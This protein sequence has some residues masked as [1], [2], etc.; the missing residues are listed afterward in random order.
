[1]EQQITREDAL[2]RKG[3]K[4][5]CHIMLYGDSSA[6][7]FG[8]IPIKHI[9]LITVI[10]MQ[11]R[12]DGLLGFPG[13]LVNPSNETLEA[14]LSRE[15]HEE[16]GVAVPVGV[17]NHVSTC[18]SSSCPGLI[19]HFYIKKMA[20]SEL[21]ELETAAVAKATDHGLEV[22]GMV[23]VP[24]YFLRNGGGLPYFLSHS[25]ISNSR[26]QLLSALQ[27]CRLLSQ[28]EIEKAVSQA[29]QMRRTRS[30]DPH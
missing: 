3:Y 24:L 1:M 6:K 9:V 25:F 2:T 21:K 4:H 30:G 19:T 16:V 23:R 18:L 28:G 27:R 7:L 13:G 14:G 15:L 12:F 22:L 5:A 11:M 17:D 26:A 20:E 8:K 10:Q 29:E